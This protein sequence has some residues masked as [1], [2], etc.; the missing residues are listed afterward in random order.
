MDEK[1]SLLP[2]LSACIATL[3][4]GSAVVA[5]RI[6]VAEVDAMTLAFLRCAGSGLVI[7]LLM[8][9]VVGVRRLRAFA[10]R[11]V[12]VIVVLG[13]AQYAVFGWM[14]ARGLFY[15][16]AARGALLMSTYPIQTL[17]L[18]AALGRERLTVLKIMGAAVAISGVAIAFADRA[19]T[20]NP[21]FW[22]G[23]LL[24][25][26]AAFLG[27]VYNVFSG[28]YLRRYPSLG[29]MSIQVTAGALVLGVGTFLF[30]RWSGL[31]DLSTVSWGAIAW[32]CIPGGLAGIYLWV[33][34]LEHIAPSRVS[35]AVTLNPIAA[36]ALG[37]LLLEE[38][39]TS[40]LGI[41]LAAIILGLT[42]ANWP[43]RAPL[44]S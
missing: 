32:L 17:I 9:L 21:E 23:D 35:M 31:G 22:K 24:M 19:G 7:I 11:D 6:A 5:T 36:A 39:V 29:V 41:G 25:L 1:R 33:W 28:P 40:R 42:L 14:F 37:A 18:A 43:A 34:A 13:V 10:A 15:I 12:G 38:P 27:S 16:P 3:W 20:D 4:G 2:V 8:T 26:G 44:A 30:G